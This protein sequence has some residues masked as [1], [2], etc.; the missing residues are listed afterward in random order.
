VS[1]SPTPAPINAKVSPT[2]RDT[3]VSIAVA[4]VA[5]ASIADS[6]PS[7]S[8]TASAPKAPA[9][10]VSQQP[11]KL[12]DVDYAAAAAE[13]DAQDDNAPVQHFQEAPG[14]EWEEEMVPVPVNTD[15]LES[16]LEMGVED[17]RVRKGL[18]HGGSL[19]GAMSCLADHQDDADIDQPYMVK[20]SDTLPK[21]P[22]SEEQQAMH[23]QATEDRV[24]RKRQEEKLKQ[25]MEVSNAGC[26]S[27]YVIALSAFHVLCTNLVSFFL[28]LS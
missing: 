1:V 4:S 25:E 9:P 15:L 14:Q 13:L 19:D 26:F 23:V 17:V 20:K 12:D 2:K 24:A 8:T 10:A 3:S 22:L 21:P 18:A 11:Q 27:V 16:L 5:S 6:K 28:S 7:G